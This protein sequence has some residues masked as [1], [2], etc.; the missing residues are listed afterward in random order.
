M[1]T[2][3]SPKSLDAFVL[4]G[5]AVGRMTVAAEVSELLPACRRSTQ[6]L[7]FSLPQPAFSPLASVRSMRKQ[8]LPSVTQRHIQLP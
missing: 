6:N 3:E 4:F 1:G 8:S 5:L 2:D 7:V